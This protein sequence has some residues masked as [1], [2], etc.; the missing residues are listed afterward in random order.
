[1]IAL[2]AAPRRYAVVA[3]WLGAEGPGASFHYHVPDGLPLMPGHLVVVPLGNRRAQGVV[4]ELAGRAP[5]DETRPIETVVDPRPVLTREQIEL[6]RWVADRYLTPLPRVLA[7]MVPVGLRATLDQQLSLR[8]SGMDPGAL[9][10]RERL[11]VDYL[12]ERGPVRLRTL[13]ERLALPHASALV[14]RLARRGLVERRP[15]M[16]GAPGLR[17]AAPR[18]AALTPAGADALARG[19]VARAPRQAEALA[20]LG[21]RPAGRVDLEQLRAET[22]LEARTLKLLIERGWVRLEAAPAPLRPIERLVDPARPPRLTA[23]QEAALARLTRAVESG[24][25]GAF[26]LHGVTASGKTEVYLRLIQ[27][28]LAGGRR[29]LALVPEIGLTPQ[30]IHRYGA[31]FPGRVVVLHSRLTA[32]DRLDAWRRIRDG[33]ADVVVGSRSALLA[34][35]PELGVIVVDEEHEPSYKQP[36]APRYHAR[37]TALALGRIARAVVVLGSATPDVETYERAWRGELGLI[38]MRSRAPVRSAPSRMPTVE[39]VDLRRAVAQGE[40]PLFSRR[41]VELLGQTLSRR[42]QA[43]LFLNRRGAA[44]VVI[45]AGCGWVPRCRR[46]DVTLVYHAVGD[47]LRCHQCNRSERAPTTCPICRSTR[48]QYLGAGTQRVVLELQRLFPSAR[49]LRWDKDAMRRRLAADELTRRFAEREADVLVGTQAIAKGLD[50]PGVTLVGIISADTILHLPD[51][52]AVERTFQLLTQVAGRAGRGERP[53]RVV[54]QTYSPE[55]PCIAAAARQ[56]YGPFVQAELRFRREH[57]YPP[58]AELVRAVYQSA[59]IASARAASA[60]QA[61]ALR[62]AARSVPA[63]VDVIGPAP[64]YYARVRGR[65]RW[66]L[67]LRGPGARDLA[68]TV[69]WSPGWAVD[70]DPVSLL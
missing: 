37:E 55:H 20:F 14:A 28:A 62:S 44:T 34:P 39:V 57:G 22:G 64:C 30:A 11:V 21:Q 68:R 16:V 13:R 54:L 70:V 26:L 61:A 2:A 69:A 18:L 53:G 17:R 50:L 32:A 41:L 47:E 49:V 63:P 5:V 1:V 67:L 45:C 66:Q 4:V 25:G 29:A 9:G 33:R 15:L 7:A 10:R 56:S 43:I 38:E 52:R 31:R 27:A 51:M 36:A 24:R 23:D 6:A 3:V 59:S 65:H 42:E 58:Y 48:L 12:R 60:R 8:P 40:D 35:I 46:C 19:E